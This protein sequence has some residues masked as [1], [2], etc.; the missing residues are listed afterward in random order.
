[1]ILQR[2]NTREAT[3]NLDIV[4]Y[5]CNMSIVEHHV[6][7]QQ[8]TMRYYYQQNKIMNSKI[9]KCDRENRIVAILHYHRYNITRRKYIL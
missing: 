6:T 8:K 4:A 1:V 3:E 5:A 9:L 7:T 2:T